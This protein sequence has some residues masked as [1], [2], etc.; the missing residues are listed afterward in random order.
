VIQAETVNNEDEQTE[1]PEADQPASCSSTIIILSQSSQVTRPTRS[2]RLTCA[3]VQIGS[4]NGSQL[5]KM[6][7]FKLHE[8]LSKLKVRVTAIHQHGAS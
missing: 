2:G 7:G 5:T 6:G 1:L 4:E 3:L 8:L